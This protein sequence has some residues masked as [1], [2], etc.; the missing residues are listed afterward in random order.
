[1]PSRNA[2]T[3]S[4]N[5]TR[6]FADRRMSHSSSVPRVAAKRRSH[7]SSVNLRVKARGES[8]AAWRI[9]SEYAFPTPLTMRGIRQCP[10]QSPVLTAQRGAEAGQIGRESVYASRVH[11]EQA[12]PARHHV[13]RCPPLGAGLRERERS[14]REIESR[15]VLAPLEGR[16]GRLPM[17]AAGDHQVQHQPEVAIQADGDALSHSPQFAHGSS[18]GFREGGRGGS[19]KKRAG[20][21]DA[22]ERQAHHARFQRCDVSRDVRQFGHTSQLAW[23]RRVWQGLWEGCR[24]GEGAEPFPAAGSRRGLLRHGRADEDSETPVAFPVGA[25]SPKRSRRGAE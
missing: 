16:V 11:G 10:L 6:A 5:R 1:M 20:Q 17:Q 15:Q 24:K 4:G 14:R 7:S 18:R 21:P 12:G 2:V 23:A 13:E 9:S 22:F 25:P 8:R 19:K 3:F